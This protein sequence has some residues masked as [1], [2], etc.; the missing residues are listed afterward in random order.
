MRN[1]SPAGSREQTGYFQVDDHRVTGGAGHR[2]RRVDVGFV[3]QTVVGDEFVDSAQVVAQHDPG[4]VDGL[5]PHPF[6]PR[7]ISG[8]L[9]LGRQGV[10]VGLGA[11]VLACQHQR[12]ARSFA[13]IGQHP[14]YRVLAEKPTA[15]R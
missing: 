14:P 3:G 13:Q 15:Q 1:R 2:G 11:D 7:R 5:D 8:N 6:S 4:I 9:V 10:H 12:R